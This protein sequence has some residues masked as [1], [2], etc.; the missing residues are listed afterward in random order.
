VRLALTRREPPEALG[1]SVESFARYV[2]PEVKMVR[3]GSLRLFPI[4][5]LERWLKEN[6]SS[7]VEDLSKRGAGVV[8]RRQV[9]RRLVI[10]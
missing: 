9:A 4:S 2:Q 8:V 5:D 3:R 1:I 7:M 6:G 10:G